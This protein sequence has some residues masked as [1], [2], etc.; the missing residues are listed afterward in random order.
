MALTISAVYSNERTQQPTEPLIMS[1]LLVASTDTVV[2][3]QTVI[4][5][6]TDR[7][8]IVYGMMIET[9][10]AVSSLLFYDDTTLIMRLIGGSGANLFLDLRNLPLILTASNPLKFSKNYATTKVYMNIWTSLLD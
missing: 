9:D 8:I 7:R 4:A 1:N 10:T 5:G 3:A 6:T 2:T